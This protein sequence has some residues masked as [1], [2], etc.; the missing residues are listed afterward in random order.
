MSSGHYLK[1]LKDLKDLKK[2]LNNKEKIL[3]RIITSLYFGVSQIY[4]GLSGAMAV[5]FY[6]PKNF[7]KTEIIKSYLF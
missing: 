1:D 2:L 4:L 3:S 6:N 7:I 5:F